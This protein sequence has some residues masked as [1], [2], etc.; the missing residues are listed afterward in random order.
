[1]E[2]IGG[3]DVETDWKDRPLPDTPDSD[4]LEQLYIENGR[5][6]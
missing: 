4:L 5:R 3:D 2:N 6:L 1:M